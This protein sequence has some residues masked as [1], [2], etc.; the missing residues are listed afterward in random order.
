MENPFLVIYKSCGFK[1][2]PKFPR[3]IDVE[4]TNCCNLKCKMCKGVDTKRPKGYMSEKTFHKILKEI[5]PHGT[6]VRFIRWG[7]PTLHKRLYDWI[8]ACRE[9]HLLTHL[10][11][12]GVL[13]DVDEVLDSGLESIKFSFQG[14]DAQE[15]K[16]WR[17]WDGFEILRT[18]IERLHSFNPRPFI[19]VGTTTTGGN[20]LHF[21]EKFKDIADLVSVG[22]TRDY[23]Q[24]TTF[25]DCPEVWDNLSI[26]WDGTVTACCSDSENLMKVGDIKETP[27]S[28]IWKS[29]KLQSYRN[30]LRNNGHDKLPLCKSCVL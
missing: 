17:G 29:S 13:L 24:R 3:I 1:D 26:N 28:F 12:N 21:V 15:F 8:N 9:H 7:E 30:L 4:L 14:T 18:K 27:L 2:V 23:T 20:H 25:P 22:Q 5:S 16:T 19:Q 11:T 6:A 10:N